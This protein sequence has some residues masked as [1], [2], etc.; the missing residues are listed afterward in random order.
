[1]TEMAVCL[2]VGLMVCHSG[3]RCKSGWIDRDAVWFED[4]G[5]PKEPR[6][7]WGPH[8]PAKFWGRRGRPIVGD[9]VIICAKTAEPIKM[10]FG[11]WARMGPINHVLNGVQIYQWEGTVWG[12]GKNGPF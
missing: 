12:G 6:I 3:E 4:S 8:P 10:P 5:G 1:M 9:S 7:R 2:S 11:L